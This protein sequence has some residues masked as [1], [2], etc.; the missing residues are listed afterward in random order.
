MGHLNKTQPGMVHLFHLDQAFLRSYRL[1]GFFLLQ[2]GALG[3]R[4]GFN[5]VV[6]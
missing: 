5:I 6:L 3:V 2:K 1:K 4:V